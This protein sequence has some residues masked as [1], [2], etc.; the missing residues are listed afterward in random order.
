[1]AFKGKNVHLIGVCG[2]GMFPLALLLCAVGARVRGIDRT[3]SIEKHAALAESGAS[4]ESDD[5]N[6]PAHDL[7]PPED[8][9]CIASPAIPDQHPDLRAAR[10]LGVKVLYRAEALALLVAERESICIAGSHGK[11]TTTAM[12]AWVFDTMLGA[13]NGYM[14]GADLDDPL[15]ARLGTESAPFLMEACEAYGAL[16]VWTPSHAILTN[17]DDEHVEQYGSDAALDAAYAAFLAKVPAGGAIVIDGD[18]AR[19]LRLARQTGRRVLTCGFGIA[20]HLRAVERPGAILVDREG[21][22]LGVLRLTVAGHHNVRNALLVLGMALEFGLEAEHVLAALATFRGVKRR[23]QIVSNA[24]QPRVIDDFA[25]HPAEI[26]T[27]LLT[28]R[29]DTPGRLIAVLEPQLHSRVVRLADAFVTA[30]A[31]AD[32]CFILPVAALGETNRKGCGDR[33]LSDAFACAKRP[34]KAVATAD[35]LL[36]RLA[37]FVTAS[38]TVV[39]MGGIRSQDLRIGLPRVSS[40]PSARMRLDPRSF[41]ALRLRRRLICWLSWRVMSAQIPMPR[42]SRWATA[43]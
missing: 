21:V 41:L 12:L 40:F 11:S 27:A 5:G 33:A 9:L 13:N 26:S 25:H 37:S 32:R 22:P 8:W 18:S 35:D 43:S 24:E 34:F 7:T 36:E 17:V 16:S 20:N 39:V 29:D 3:I 42:Q 10:R 30:L 2:S 6:S 4:V 15:P 1:M 19:T 14:V 28:L 23:L 31:H 38:D